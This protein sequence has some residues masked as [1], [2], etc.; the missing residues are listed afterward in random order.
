MQLLDVISEKEIPL[1][2]IPNV[3]DYKKRLYLVFEYS[4]T[5]LSKLI[6]HMKNTGD[7]FTLTQVQNIMKQ[8]LTGLNLMHSKMILHRDLKP[9]NILIDLQG[10]NVKIADFGLSKQAKFH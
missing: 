5:T 3:N 7:H 6:E 9:D 4:E 2:N 10:E 1:I 8:L